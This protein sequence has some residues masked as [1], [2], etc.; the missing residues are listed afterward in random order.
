M[1]PKREG[2][3]Y[4]FGTFAYLTWSHKMLPCSE[5]LLLYLPRVKSINAKVGKDTSKQEK[6]NAKFFSKTKVFGCF[7]KINSFLSFSNILRISSISKKLYTVH[8]QYVV[9]LNAKCKISSKWRK[10]FLTVLKLHSVYLIGSCFFFCFFTLYYCFVIIKG[11]FT[12]CDSARG[13]QSHHGK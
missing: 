12:L 3:I 9:L 13:H 8:V 4:L 5:T 1:G 10:T 6:K 11:S 2:P 7:S